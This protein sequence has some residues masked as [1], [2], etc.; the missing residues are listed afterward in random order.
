MNKKEMEKI[1]GS[2]GGKG[3]EKEKRKTNLR[4]RSNLFYLIRIF[5]KLDTYNAFRIQ[6]KTLMSKRF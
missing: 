6:H 4:K 5:L 3:K 2:Q 1:Q